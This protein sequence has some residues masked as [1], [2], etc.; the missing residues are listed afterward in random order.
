MAQSVTGDERAA[1]AGR[2]ALTR[3]RQERSR[4]CLNGFRATA[5]AA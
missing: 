1:E 3:R 5:G 2:T 4:A